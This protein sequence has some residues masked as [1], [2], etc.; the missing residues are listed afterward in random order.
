MGGKDKFIEL[1][2]LSNNEDIKEIVNRWNRLSKS[3]RRY[4][5]LNNLIDGTGITEVSLVA[6]VSM[7]AFENDLYEIVVLIANAP[8]E[9]YRILEK[10]LEGI[11]K[12]EGFKERHRMARYYEL[13][14]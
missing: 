10:C 7:C 14:N 5:S 4:I 11:S 6:E 2:S 9:Q 1:A 13:I 3:D 12:E 8:M